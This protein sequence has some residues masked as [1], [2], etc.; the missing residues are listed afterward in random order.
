QGHIITWGIMPGLSYAQNAPRDADGKPTTYDAMRREL[1]TRPALRQL[2]ELPVTYSEPLSDVTRI[3]HADGTA[4][5]LVDFSYAPGR[6]ATLTVH[7]D[8][9]ISSVTG[10][11]HGPYDF[12]QEGRAVTI[13][14]PTPESVEVL[15]LK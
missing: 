6:D 12:T 14:C 15:L 9:R 5:I 8:R 10:S 11:L 1:V 4:V 2:G 13:T 3:D 7:T